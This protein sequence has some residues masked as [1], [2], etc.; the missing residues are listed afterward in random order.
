MALIPQ[1]LTLIRGD[2]K[3]WRVTVTDTETPAVAINLDQDLAGLGGNPAI[4]KFSTKVDPRDPNSAAVIFKASYDPEEVEILDQ[5]AFLGQA[6]VKVV[7]A[8]TWND[9]VSSA[10]AW[11][12]ELYR[13]GDAIV[14]GDAGTI[15]VT[16]GSETVAGTGTDFALA[17]VGDILVPSGATAPNQKPVTVTEVVSA[18]ELKTDYTAWTSEAGVSY[19]LRK[20]DSKTVAT[21]T[22]DLQQD[23]TT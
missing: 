20:G 18:T 21:G 4:L 6:L 5:G 14:G 3:N 19:V 12:I 11:D 17:K 10:L 13:Q 16:A 9:Q 23:Q 22:F 8:D 15:E 7:K 2:S 1:A